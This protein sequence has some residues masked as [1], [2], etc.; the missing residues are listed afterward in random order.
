[1]LVGP[2]K[3]CQGSSPVQ[4]VQMPGKEHL[5]SSVSWGQAGEFPFL[6]IPCSLAIPHYILHQKQTNK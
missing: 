6:P 5:P 4:G 1:M 3:C 2:P